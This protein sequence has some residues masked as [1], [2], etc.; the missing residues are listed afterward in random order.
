MSGRTK[1]KEIA[2]AVGVSI[3]TVSNALSGR[4]RVSAKVRQKVAEVAERMDYRPDP[5]LRALCSYRSASGERCTPL[6]IAFVVHGHLDIADDHWGDASRLLQGMRDESERRGVQ[7][8][9]FEHDGSPMAARQL[10]RVLYSR[11]IRCLVLSFPKHDAIEHPI[12]LEW[13]KFITVAC[14]PIFGQSRFHSVV[15]DYFWQ[16]QNALV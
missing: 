11:G 16:R 7:V 14:K 4:G 2:E 15:S 13:E 10:S 1:L 8:E 5:M 3:S 12:E 9:V 6:H